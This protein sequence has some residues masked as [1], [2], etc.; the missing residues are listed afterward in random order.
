MAGTVKSVVRPV[1]TYDRQVQ[2]L[3]WRMVKSGTKPEALE[4]YARD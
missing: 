3:A 1:Q 4:E 2:K